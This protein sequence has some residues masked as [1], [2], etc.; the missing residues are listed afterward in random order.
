M[1][2]LNINPI[3]IEPVLVAAGTTWKWQRAY[4]QY[5]STDYTL[6]YN[7]R[8]VRGVD[9]FDITA[10]SS[11]TSTGYDIVVGFV[12]TGNIQPGIYAGR[13]YVS[14][15]ADRYMVYDNQIEVMADFEQVTQGQD[16]RTH[17][18]KVL[19]QIKALL[20]N[21]F[22]DDSQSYSI[23]GRSLTKMT[24]TELYT[25]K[26]YYE[27]QVIAENRRA[28]AK[29]NLPTGQTIYGVFNNGL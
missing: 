7:F 14:D 2:D 18:A 21:K 19:E 15:A 24:P 25:H 11:A 4:S 1:S 17:N 3:N 20:E 28:R 29:Q 16:L 9:S 5:P 6:I 13:G 23:A 10:T 12:V 26:L 22:V 27:Q 8:E